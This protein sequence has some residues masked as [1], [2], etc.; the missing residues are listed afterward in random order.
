VCIPTVGA[1]FASDVCGSYPFPFVGASITDH[2]MS[3]ILEYQQVYFLGNRERKVRGS[4]LSPY[5]K[6]SPLL[7]SCVGFVLGFGSVLQLGLWPAIWYTISS[8]LIVSLSYFI[9]SLGLRR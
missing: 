3:E 2:E 1:S 8:Y 5:N 9:L 4:A 6:V 7:A